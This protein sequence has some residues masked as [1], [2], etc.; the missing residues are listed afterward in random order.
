MF[1]L[2]KT[3]IYNQALNDLAFWYWILKDFQI[4]TPEKYIVKNNVLL[5]NNI[6]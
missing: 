6:K 2:E 5:N 4:P 3:I 1:E